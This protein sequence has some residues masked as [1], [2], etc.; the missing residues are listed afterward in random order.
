MKAI[1]DFKE[2]FVS[3]YTRLETPPT[4]LS[5][6]QRAMKAEPCMVTWVCGR[7][8]D[9]DEWCKKQFT[10]PVARIQRMDQLIDVDFDCVKDIVLENFDFRGV[11]THYMLNMFKRSMCGH[12]LYHFYKVGNMVM[13]LNMEKIRVW[14]SDDNIPVTY[15]SPAI[16]RDSSME[17][18]ESLRKYLKVFFLEPV[19]LQDGVQDASAPEETP[20]VAD[21]TDVKYV[22]DGQV[23]SCSRNL[24]MLD[25]SD[26]MEDDSQSFT[27]VD[28]P[29]VDEADIQV[30]DECMYAEDDS[31]TEEKRLLENKVR[32]YFGAG[33][34][35]I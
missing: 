1:S 15:F 12:R 26:P 11:S 30:V 35:N 4:Q 14:V 25:L 23:A 2:S 7:Q 22:E 6:Y 13:S 21:T 18:F 20:S 24:K 17:E 28:I 16:K 3:E 27:A 33:K 10:G 31:E 32:E 5:L 19:H 34:Y 8:P 9:R 29:E